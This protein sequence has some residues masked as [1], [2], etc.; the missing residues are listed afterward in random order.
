[1]MMVLSSMAISV[2]HQQAAA[3]ITKDN[4]GKGVNSSGMV[5]SVRVSVPVMALL[6]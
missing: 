4:I 3:A 5:R 1:M 6:A 2:C